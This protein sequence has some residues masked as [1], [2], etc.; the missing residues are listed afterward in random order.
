MT[1]GKRARDHLLHPETYQDRQESQGEIYD[2]PSKTRRKQAT[3]KRSLTYLTP[4]PTY[5]SIYA[6]RYVLYVLFHLIDAGEG[7]H[8]RSFFRSYFLNKDVTRN[9]RGLTIIWT[10]KWT[11]RTRAQK[12]T[13][14]DFLILYKW[15]ITRLGSRGT[16]RR[17]E[18]SDLLI[19]SNK[20]KPPHEVHS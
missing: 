3:D 9:S 15:S 19:G 8:K 2:K 4:S 17:P 14:R 13:C 7:R 16:W 1:G 5:H 18:K 12:T 20:F 10:G 11:E 6:Y